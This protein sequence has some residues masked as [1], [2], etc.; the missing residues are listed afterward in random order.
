MPPPFF[1]GGGSGEDRHG[2]RRWVFG[3]GSGTG[4]DRDSRAFAL[5]GL[6]PHECPVVR[7]QGPQITV[8]ANQQLVAIGKQG[9]EVSFGCLP[10]PENAPIATIQCKD[11]AV[12][13]DEGGVVGES[14]GSRLP[15]T[16]SWLPIENQDWF[17][18]ERLGETKNAGPLRGVRRFCRV[19]PVLDRRPLSGRQSTPIRCSSTNWSRSW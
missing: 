9:H 18:M 3:A 11:S 2:C 7:P 6:A 4:Q 15:P 8:G 17:P 16:V 19:R 12:E 10:A 5:E 1:L 14:H 13:G